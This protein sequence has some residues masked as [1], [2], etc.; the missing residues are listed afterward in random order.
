MGIV[1]SLRRIPMRVKHMM[2]PRLIQWLLVAASGDMV[3]R[4]LMPIS[5]PRGLR[6]AMRRPLT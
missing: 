5:A 2:M 6:V 1:R 3:D 4:G